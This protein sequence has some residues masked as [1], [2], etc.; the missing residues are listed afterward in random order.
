MRTE[1][2]RWADIMVHISHGPDLHAFEGEFRLPLLPAIWTPDDLLASPARQALEN[3]LPRF[4]A[5]QR[6]FGGKA[7]QMDNV[8]IVD[9][10][11][12]TATP[13][14]VFLV[15][16]QVAYQDG[17]TD[18]YFFPLTTVT[19]SA[20]TE[21]VH[22]LRGRVLA[23]FLG[24]HGTGL[25]VDALA[26]EPACQA[27]LSAI[28]HRRAVA[29]RT[30]EIRAVPTNAY[31]ELRGPDSLPLPAAPGPATS[32][33]SLVRFG[34]RLLF[35]IFR[36]LDVGINPDLEISRF[37]TEKTGFRAVPRTAGFVEYHRPRAEPI[38][39]GIL[40]ELV[41]NEGDGWR[42][43]L[44]EL[45][46]YFR[47]TCPTLG[48]QVFKER[49][50][51][52]EWK[53]GEDDPPPPAP[54]AIGAYL[55]EAAVLGKRT[56]EL[57]RALATD[58]CDRALAPEPV[59][60]TDLT[61][62]AEEARGQAQRALELLGRTQHDQPEMSR[63]LVER[64][65]DEAPSLL[66]QLGHLSSANF[67]AAKIRCHGDYHLAQ[68]LRVRGDFV[69]LD[70]EGEPS[71]SIAR[72]RTKQSPLKDVAGMLRSFNYAAYAGLF[73][74]TQHRPEDLERLVPSAE[75]WQTWVSAA[76]L[77]EYRTVAGGAEFL[78]D[79][80]EHF[81]ILLRFFMLDKACYELMYELNNRPDWV[82]I[83]LQGILALSR[84]GAV[85]CLQ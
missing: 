17:T 29:T 76:F 37:L 81:A 23:S 46:G 25:L 35:K 71:R 73:S 5:D 61:S 14:P 80:P 16:A 11:M 69:I 2:E 18:V 84:E 31:R 51:D 82:R 13:S 45:E 43:A 10:A 12:L 55:R 26:I 63:T 79:N 28:A 68:V 21:M 42:H 48:S 3:A 34:G 15:I 33:N 38:T 53:L 40:Q 24:A 41:A 32:S 67:A 56:A 57:H 75:F 83:P 50:D 27:L 49:H 58:K 54:Q 72:R 65:S 78:P 6:W 59:T 19:M 47:R 4:L 30:A 77:Q 60:A 66:D 74:F 20:A 22:A 62:W 9:W 44:G 8:R 36:R 64:V 85:P 39:L 70:F 7:N 1:A 52:I